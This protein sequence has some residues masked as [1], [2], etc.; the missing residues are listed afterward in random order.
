MLYK[1][2]KEEYLA[3]AKKYRK[4]VYKPDWDLQEKW[5]SIMKLRKRKQLNKLNRK[6]KGIDNDEFD[7]FDDEQLYE[8]LAEFYEFL[9]EDRFKEFSKQITEYYSENKKQKAQKDKN[10][11]KGLFSCCLGG[12]KNKI[13]NKDDEEE[14]EDNKE[15]RFQRMMELH[16]DFNRNLA[17][18]LKDA[19]KRDKEKF[20]QK[21]SL[22]DFYIDFQK[23]FEKYCET[24][25]I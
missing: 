23:N 17:I 1:G 4:R 16:E 18:K 13:E 15:N 9:Y 20:T 25:L 19:E 7:N 6:L 2:Q 12:R 10:N 11:E 22:E 14:E 3:N 24:S 5:P 8:Y 21:K